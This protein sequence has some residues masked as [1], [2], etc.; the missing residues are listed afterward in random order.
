M[1]ALAALEA[2]LPE[3]GSIATEILSQLRAMV[4]LSNS[5]E[6]AEV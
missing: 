2:L 4:I 3:V 5:V 1:G 6:D